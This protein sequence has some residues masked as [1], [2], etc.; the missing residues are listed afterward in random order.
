MCCCI[1]GEPVE[2]SK[3]KIKTFHPDGRAKFQTD[4]VI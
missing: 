4:M 1:S 3:G 2:D